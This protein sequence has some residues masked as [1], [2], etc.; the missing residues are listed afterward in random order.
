MNIGR[1]DFPSASLVRD[2]QGTFEAEGKTVNSLKLKAQRVVEPILIIL[3]A[4]K[5]TAFCAVKGTC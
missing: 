1:V 5:L 4:S 2:S 3:I